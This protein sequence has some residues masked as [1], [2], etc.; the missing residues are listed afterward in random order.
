MEFSRYCCIGYMPAY[1]Y[2]DDGYFQNITD[3]P[4]E[5]HNNLIL[6]QIPDFHITS[7][8][9]LCDDIFESFQKLCVDKMGKNR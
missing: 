8:F 2:G 7:P 6:N 5:H 4:N 3:T 9:K 1:T